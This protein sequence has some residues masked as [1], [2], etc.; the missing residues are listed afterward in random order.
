MSYDKAAQLLTL[1]GP[2]EGTKEHHD[3]EHQIGFSYRQVLGELMY[4]FVVCRLDI[5][6]AVTLLSRMSSSPHH[7]HYTAL[8]KIAKYL[9]ATKDWGLIYWRS[10]PNLAFPDVPLP[11]IPV[12]PNLPSFPEVPLDNLSSFVDATNNNN[13][14]EILYFNSYSGL[15]TGPPHW[16]CFIV[17]VLFASDRRDL[18]RKDILVGDRPPAPV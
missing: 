12:D 4:A 14:S 3:L 1:E 17:Y 8:L 15:P 16:E 6:Y 9:R 7:E 13:K 10:V 2:K 11:E 18:P 5:G